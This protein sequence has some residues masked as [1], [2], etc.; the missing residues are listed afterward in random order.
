MQR[1]QLGVVPHLH[2]GIGTGDARLCWF[3]SLPQLWQKV[4]ALFRAVDGT[5]ELREVIQVIM[6]GCQPWPRYIA[7]EL[8]ISAREVDNRMKRLRRCAS[9]LAKRDVLQSR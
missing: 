9:K 4:E 6:D 2:G 3:T 7:L 8:N 1:T 5:L